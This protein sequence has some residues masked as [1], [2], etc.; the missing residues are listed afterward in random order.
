MEPKTLETAVGEEYMHFNPGRFELRDESGWHVA[1]ENVVQLGS[2]R[3]V[4]RLITT[5]SGD[6]CRVIVPGVFDKERYRSDG[7]GNEY[8]RVDYVPDALKPPFET[9]VWFEL[10]KQFGIVVLPEDLR[11]DYCT[12]LYATQRP[13]KRE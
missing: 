6:I 11:F 9:M 12:E 10:I 13:Q 8:S 2:V 5:D 1:F 7:N 4:Y 3:I